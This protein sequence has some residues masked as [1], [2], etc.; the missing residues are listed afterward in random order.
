M[1]R[2]IRKISKI[3]LIIALV[4]LYSYAIY[5]INT[6]D[7]S[8]GYLTRK[9]KDFSQFPGVVAD[10]FNDIKSKEG[11]VL[12]EADFSPKNELDYDVYALNSTYETSEW[13]TRLVNLKNDSVLHEWR[14]KKD[15][16][17][18]K[19]TD[20]IFARTEPR[21][22]VLLEDR[23]IILTSD[24]SYNIYRLDKDSKVI[25][26]NT[27]Y[28]Y[29]HAINPDK[30]GNIW[31][32][33]KTKLYMKNQGIEY[34]DNGIAKIDV[35]T[36]KTLSYTSIS[37]VLMENELGYLVFGM[38][39]TD[40]T[41]KVEIDPLH[42]N[43][44]EPVLKD[45]PYW[46]TGDL[47]LSFRHR[48]LILLYRPA[49]GKILR[50]IHGP[51]YNQHDVDIY[52]DSSISFFNNNASMLSTI[53][54]KDKLNESDYHIDDSLSVNVTS[55]IMIYNFADST[56]TTKYP[57]HFESENIY[58]FSQGLHHFLENGDVFVESQNEA[59]IFIFNEDELILKDYMNP[60]T[61]SLSELTHW[62]SIYE[63]I[64]F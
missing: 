42:L 27:D 14:L 23:D 34:W 17:N 5:Y 39:N 37:D 19:N 61:D 10:V 28:R 44:V 1:T 22:P 46:K 18:E 47:F 24:E 35:K 7:A 29:H 41:Y 15:S 20:R 60:P 62:I 45:G 38:G 11:Y 13:V 2:I 8:L 52:S 57:V 30:E 50:V 31:A 36:G 3:I 53:K 48:S 12:Q 40:D 64:N 21:T 55:G 58:S 63:D 6:E 9:L 59:K 26:H 32:C 43:D 4:N 16:F 56:F 49:T 51:F 54:K 33:T 25:W